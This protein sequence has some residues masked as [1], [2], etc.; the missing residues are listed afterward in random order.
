MDVN[1][2]VVIK[3]F[4]GAGLSY[5][6]LAQSLS[7]IEM[8]S[9]PLF[10]DALIEL[11]VVDFGP[12][13][14]AKRINSCSSI[15]ELK[16]GSSTLAFQLPIADEAAIKQYLNLPGGER[17]SPFQPCGAKSQWLIPANTSMYQVQVDAR[18]LKHV[19]GAQALK[20]YTELY[21]TASRKAYDPTVLFAAATAT[22]HALNVAKK[23][24]ALAL[25]ISNSY[26]EGLVTDILLPCI[27]SDLEDVK[28]STRQ[29]IL[30]KALGYIN[31][32]HVK[33][34]RLNELA[35]F[36]STSVRNL[37]M[38]FKQ[39]LGISPSKYI[40]QFRLHRFRLHLVNSSS[41]TEAA[42]MS[43]FKHLGRLTEQYAKVFSTYPSDDLLVQSEFKLDLRTSFTLDS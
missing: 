12:L 6:D 10:G 39:E 30:S 21:K 18:W 17:Y 25:P 29:K 32:H 1:N 26:L 11:D 41:V 43:G 38:V 28:A 2:Q 27:M 31:T 4:E 34:I 9:T 24:E 7:C 14:I 35:E 23:S 8:T 22:E 5:F 3:V 42:Y 40:H 37:Q 15:E 16:F 33:P 20:D 13:L 19:L 36:V